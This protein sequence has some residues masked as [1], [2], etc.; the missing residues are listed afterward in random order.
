M[1]KPPTRLV[2]Y[3]GI[4]PGQRG[5][6]VAITPYTNGLGILVEAQ[7]MPT[8]E[9]DVWEWFD[10]LGGE[11]I[12]LIE[13]VHAMPK[14]GVT[15]MFTFGKGYGFL[16]ACLIASGTAF[17]EVTPQAWLKG[18]AIPT[19]KKKEGSDNA[20]K[21]YLRGKA[22]QLFPS[23]EIW[24]QKD[25]LGKQRAISDALLIAEWCRRKHNGQSS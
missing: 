22:Q 13:A 25:V 5:G 17:E 19:G 3:I 12:A 11:R 23:L 4:D 8:N 18:L 10:G 14:Q 1:P 20:W 2:T 15:S 16:R 9:R 6:L 21:D 24:S 7:P